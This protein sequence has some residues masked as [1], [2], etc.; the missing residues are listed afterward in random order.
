MKDRASTKY[1][2]LPGLVHFPGCQCRCFWWQ[3]AV[4]LGKIN[5]SQFLLTARNLLF[6]A[7]ASLLPAIEPS[8]SRHRKSW[9]RVESHE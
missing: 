1:P 8:L 9:E 4:D 6:A 2:P 7:P 5:A 3:W